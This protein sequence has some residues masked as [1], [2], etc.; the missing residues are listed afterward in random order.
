[1]KVN[2]YLAWRRM[3]F[4]YWK[5]H[6]Y[7]CVYVPK[8]EIITKSCYHFSYLGLSFQQQVWHRDLLLKIWRES[9]LRFKKSLCKLVRL[10]SLVGTISRYHESWSASAHTKQEVLFITGTI[11]VWPTKI[12]GFP[13]PSM[14]VFHY[15]LSLW[16]F[17]FL[18]NNTVFIPK[19]IL[20]LKMAF[21][22]S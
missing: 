6:T 9:L 7:R 12:F 18:F 4:L 5:S 22:W 10:C 2:I 20:A 16:G 19:V 11:W 8:E 3:I 13:P 1:M 21:L 15:R 14:D 17:W